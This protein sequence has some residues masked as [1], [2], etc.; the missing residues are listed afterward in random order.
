MPPAGDLQSRSL[1]NVTDAVIEEVK[2]SQSRPL[3]EL[4]PIVYLDALMVKVGEGAFSARS[5]RYLFHV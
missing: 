5:I 1:S 4:Y 3:D 2:Q